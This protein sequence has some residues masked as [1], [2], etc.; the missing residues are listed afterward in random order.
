MSTLSDKH[1][2]DEEAAYAWVEARLWPSGP[3]CPHCKGAERITKLGGKSTRIGVHKCNACRRPFTV[4]VGTI[5]ESS[6]LKMHLWLQ[7]IFLMCSS[8]KGISTNQLHRTLRITLKSAWFLSHRIREAMRDGSLGPLGRS[9]NA[10]EA[11]E[12]YYGAK[13]VI[14]TRTKKGKPGHASKRVV[15]SLVERGGSVRSFHVERGTEAEVTRIVQDNVIRE[16]TLFTDESKLY[17]DASGLVAKHE[18][19][20]HSA[21]EYVRYERGPDGVDLIHTNSVEGYFSIFKRGMKGI[22]Q[23]CSERHLHRYLAEYD[24]RY[25]NRIKLSVNDEARTTRALQGVVGKRLT[26]RTAR[27][28]QA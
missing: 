16:A 20:K 19:V 13:D 7:A 4:K 24:F 18:A 11:D 8:K 2:H 28:G 1:F 23:H 14:T 22:Y 3:V 9:G 17:G 25:S 27:V 5:F 10:V 26:Y 6:H 21:G 12:T 15:V